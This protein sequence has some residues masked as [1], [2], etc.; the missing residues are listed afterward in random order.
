MRGN[1]E[2]RDN[3]IP[4]PVNDDLDEYEL[5]YGENA[6]KDDEPPLKRNKGPL[7]RRPSFSS[8]IYPLA[9]SLL[10]IICMRLQMHQT[11]GEL[12]WASRGTVFNEHQYWRLFTALFAHADLEHLFSNTPLFLIF[13]LF[14]Y[15][16][17]GFTLFPVVSLLI[18]AASNAVTLY[19]YPETV[20]LIGA[21]GMIYG[22]ASMWLVLYIYHDTDR[23]MT[24]RILRAIG[25]AL[26]VLFPETYNPSTSYLAHGAGFVIGISAAIIL[27]P[28]IRVK[29]AEA[30][31]NA[32]AG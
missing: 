21:S 10:F 8:V 5:Y 30:D 23:T 6:I 9:F 32:S 19:F 25:F 28:F 14:L 24:V 13:G 27:L 4:S 11:Y 12:I 3:N 15:E 26:I 22:M 17:F 31:Q 29:G 20:R 7:S 18:G 16:Y 1:K 2:K